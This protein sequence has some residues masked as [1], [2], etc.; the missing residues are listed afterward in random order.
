[1]CSSDLAARVGTGEALVTVLDRYEAPND[2]E[3]L[4]RIE[5]ALWEAFQP[6]SECA[7]ATVGRVGGHRE[8][9]AARVQVTSARALEEWADGVATPA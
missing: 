9:F 4:A 2:D 8:P 1:M 6:L 3:T 5:P 7:A